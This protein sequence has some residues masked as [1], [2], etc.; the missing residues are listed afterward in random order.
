M[1]T[2]TRI[3]IEKGLINNRWKCVVSTNA[4]GMG[5]DK[6]DLRFII[7]TQFPQS[8]VHY[9]Q[10]IG[11]AGR[12]GLPA[13]IT[14]LYNP[15]DRALPEAF[16]EGAKPSTPK[17]QKVITA[18]RNEMLG[19]KE[20]MKRTN[21]KQTQVRVIRADLI[22]QGIIREMLI[23]K[24]KKYEYIPNAPNFNPCLYEEIKKSKYL[25]MESMMEYAESQESRMKFLCRYLGDI[26]DEDL[27]NCDNTNLSKRELDNTIQW[28]QKLDEFRESYFPDLEVETKNS[29]IVNG[30]AASFYGVSNV[31]SAIHRSKYEGGGDFPD[32]LISLILKAFRKKFGS[33]KFDM[34]LYIPPTVSGPLVKN[35]AQKVSAVLKVPIYHVLEKTRQ[36]QAQKIFENHYLKCENISGAFTIGNPE[37]VKGKKIILIDDVFDSGSSI[38]EA[39]KYLSVCGAIKIAPLV[40]AKTVGGDNL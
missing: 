4:L 1:D 28:T 25:E 39:G 20:L 27:S 16:I 17:Y 10:E 14:L 13:E 22:D 24:S 19:E 31:G 33:E 40:L 38:K 6:P 26:V 37:F 2:E 21:L 15:E 18:L 36:T 5:I 8:P 34:I 35:M 23:G 32:F 29:N 3:E 11:R 12:D 7:H 30:V 9:Y